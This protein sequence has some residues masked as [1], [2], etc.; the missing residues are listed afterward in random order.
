MKRFDATTFTTQGPRGVS[1]VSASYVFS[2][3]H[4]GKPLSLTFTQI[5]EALKTKNFISRPVCMRS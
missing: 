1:K 2:I 4:K 5:P 3:Y